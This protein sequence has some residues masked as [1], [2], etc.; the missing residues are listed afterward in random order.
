M[1]KQ[2][3]H[4]DCGVACLAMYLS[5]SY[6]EIMEMIEIRLARKAP[7][8][9]MTNVELAKILAQY[10]HRPMQ[11]FT[12]IH[13]VKA[14]LSVPSLGTKKKFHYIYWDGSNIYDPSNFDTYSKFDFSF[15]LPMADSVICENDL[16]IELPSHLF[17]HFDWEFIES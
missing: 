15:T 1:I 11:I 17:N 12:L 6:E 13:G 8:E 2:R 4:S 9:G 10:Q 16:N 3:S 5:K 14:I 7:I